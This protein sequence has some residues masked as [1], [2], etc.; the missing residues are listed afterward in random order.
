MTGYD[1]NSLHIYWQQAQLNI[2]PQLQ[3]TTLAAINIFDQF[4]LFSFFGLNIT[5]FM[6]NLVQ[7]CLYSIVSD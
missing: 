4:L 2:S 6:T 5:Y 1:I 3:E 7:E